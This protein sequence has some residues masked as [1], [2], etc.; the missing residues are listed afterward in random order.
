MSFELVDYSRIEAKLTSA[1]ELDHGQVTVNEFGGQ[2][3]LT[4]YDVARLTS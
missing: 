1:L 3:I 4:P 2:I